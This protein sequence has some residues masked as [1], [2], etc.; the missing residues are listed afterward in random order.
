[1]IINKADRT[2]YYLPKI[3]QTQIDFKQKYSSRN[4]NLYEKDTIHV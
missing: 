2:C 4:L 1:M 3:A